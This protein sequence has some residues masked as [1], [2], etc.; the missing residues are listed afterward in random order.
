MLK[1]LK[2]MQERGIFKLIPSSDLDIDTFIKGA[3]T[4]DEI[5]SNLLSIQRYIKKLNDEYTY[6]CNVPTSQYI[7]DFC[8]K[9]QFTMFDMNINSEKLNGNVCVKDIDFNQGGVATFGISSEDSINFTIQ[10]RKLIKL[11][12]HYYI[13]LKSSETNITERF[14]I[15]LEVLKTLYPE[16]VN[17]LVLKTSIEETC[18][19]LN[20]KKVYWDMAN[21]RYNKS[22]SLEKKKLNSGESESLVDITILYLP[23]TH[24]TNKKDGYVNSILGI[25]LNV[26]NF[27]KLRYEIKHIGNIFPSNAF[28]SK[29]LDFVIT[30]KVVYQ[31]NLN[32]RKNNGKLG[33]LE[34]QRLPDKVID[35]ISSKL[36]TSYKK[37]LADLTRE[38]YY[39]DKGVQ[40]VDTYFSK[41][42]NEPNSRRRILEVIDSIAR[43]ALM[44]YNNNHNC[45]LAICCRNKLI[46][47]LTTNK[48]SKIVET[49]DGNIISERILNTIGKSSS[50]GQ[51]L[52]FLRDGEISIY[53]RL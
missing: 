10:E 22:K 39:Y 23:R 53:I 16:G 9:F 25:F 45:K 6:T 8:D 20:K 47:V 12:N 34:Q 29:Y 44:L 36:K 21:T 7:S 48:D 51:I 1:T 40:T 32:T 52:K 4:E 33:K 5:I 30:E 3:T 31:L 14:Y 26:T 41:I 11:I 2:E 35:E 15:P 18:T 17:H 49:L 19:Q 28:R 27:M 13:K 42:C 37:T 38:L 50:N 24:K 43:V 46:H